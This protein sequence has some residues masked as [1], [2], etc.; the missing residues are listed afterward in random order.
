MR[1]ADSAYC[2]LI[3]M[4]RV[5]GVSQGGRHVKAI[6]PSYHCMLR[7]IFFLFHMV[8]LSIFSQKLTSILFHTSYPKHSVGLIRTTIFLI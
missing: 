5:D 2:K 7:N 6:A 1:A 4:Y 3:A 8:Q